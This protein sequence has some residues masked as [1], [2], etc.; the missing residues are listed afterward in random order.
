MTSNKLRFWAYLTLFF[1]SFASS[2]V[3]LIGQLNPLALPQAKLTTPISAS[4]TILSVDNAIGFPSSGEVAIG[5]EV[6]AYS[7]LTTTS[8]AL[9]GRGQASTT[10]AAHDAG[11]VVTFF[12]VHA[13]IL[14]SSIDA[15]ATTLNLNS[16]S[17]FPA[18]NGSM[19]IDQEILTYG[20]GTTTTLTNLVRAQEGTTAAAHNAG[21][22]IIG[23]A[24]S[25]AIQAL[26]IP[27][28]IS[29]IDSFSGIALTN[30]SDGPANV[31]LNPINSGGTPVT[32]TDS[33]GTQ[34]SASNS[35]TVGAHQQFVGGIADMLPNLGTVTDF[36]VLMTTRNP[37]ALGAVPVGNV[38]PAFGLNRLDLVPISVTDS[39]DVILPVALQNTQQFG[40]DVALELGIVTS[41]IPLDITADFVDANGNVVQSTT[42]SSLG[43]NSRVIKSLSDL[44]SNL[45]DQTIE[46]GYVHLSSLS[47][48]NA[49][50]M[51]F[52]G[53]ENAY[54]E[55]VA[56]SDAATVLNIPFAISVGPYETRLVITDGTAAVSGQAPVGVVNVRVTAFNPDG[57]V[58]TGSG[59]TNPKLV[60]F[61]VSG[62]FS[63]FISSV[64]GLGPD[65]AFSGYLKVELGPG[66][67]SSG[68]TASALILHTERNQLTSVPGQLVAMQKFT[69]TPALFD[70]QITT[71][72]SLVNPNDSP[73]AAQI[74]I[75]R[76]D[77]SLQESQTVTIPPSGQSIA[78]LSSLFP[79][80]SVES[81]GYVQITSPLALFGM[82]VFDNGT[83][84]ASGYPLRRPDE[85]VVSPNPMGLATPLDSTVP[86]EATTFPL[87]VQIPN[88]APTGGFSVNL[89][90]Q[91]PNLASLSSNLLIIP[92]G[93]TSGAVSVTSHLSGATVIDV[94]APGF[95]TSAVVV[96]VQNT[97]D[98][99]LSRNLTITPINATIPSGGTLQFALS[100]DTTNNPPVLWNV[101][102][103]L[104]GQ[105]AVGTITQSGFYTAPLLLPTDQPIRVGISATNANTT[106]FAA[107]TTVTI[108][109]PPQ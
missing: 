63:Q 3:L 11:S 35:F 62:Q 43:A 28:L 41:I 83:F 25:G 24:A 9:S 90:S 104:N 87:T 66:S 29:A 64:L 76:A 57:S 69:L 102:G 47:A 80:I 19:L 46:S 15:A 81:D 4:D 94:S 78:V 54:L 107:S 26:V 18:G 97:T 74:Q 12:P 48:F 21:A 30:L 72:L 44:F 39:T 7:S 5:T 84:L 52:V 59:V 56:R 23:R 50:E 108:L 75:I 70:L 1:S 6:L 36:Y 37:L 40:S 71:A 67:S 55:A 68:I 61:P 82:I 58:F 105:N 65:Q 34:V 13:G 103:V 98:F 51:I 79:D 77:G 32:F 86:P 20:G 2:T 100:F 42:L 27:R 92:Q 22:L 8:F 101:S 88:P 109:P 60:S 17:T 38:D 85:F 99:T 96:N 89:T 93:Q 16:T 31:I 10:A 14:T 91:N 73:A 53:R 106:F 33:T 49:Y 95:T 45:K